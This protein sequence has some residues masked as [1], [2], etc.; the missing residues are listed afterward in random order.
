[1][2]YTQLTF[3]RIYIPDWGLWPKPAMNIGPFRARLKI[4]LRGRDKECAGCGEPYGIPHM[5]EL[6]I[7]KSMVSGWVGYKRPYRV[8]I[9]TVFNCGLLCSSCNLG[10]DGKSPPSQGD[11]LRQ[12]HLVYGDNLIKW[13][14]TLPFKVHPWKGWLEQFEWLPEWLAA[15]EEGG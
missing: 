12:Q 7:P 6:F 13:M 8:L 14:A 2:A 11:A 9:N 3:S 10:Q 15:W 5:H 4:Y 1:M